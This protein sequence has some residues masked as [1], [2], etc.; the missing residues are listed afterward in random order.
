LIIDGD[1]DFSNATNIISASSIN[2]AGR[3]VD[4]YGVNLTDGQFFTFL[5]DQA[6]AH[7]VVS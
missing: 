2:A 4:F 6:A 7:L 1:A 3:Y 5:V